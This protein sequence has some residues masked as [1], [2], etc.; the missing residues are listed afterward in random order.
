MVAKGMRNW[1][2]PKIAGIVLSL[3]LV[4]G[5][6]RGRGQ[7]TPAPPAPE[8]QPLHILV[9]KSVVVNMSTR[10]KR[11]LVSNPAVIE[12]LAT[13]PS[14]VVVEAKAAGTSSLILWDESGQ[15]HM[16][17]VTVDLNL[18]PLRSAIQRA[19]P[20][21][22]VQAQADGGRIILSGIV[23]DSHITDDL[24]KM[25]GIYST[26]IVNSLTV[27]PPHQ[28]QILLEVRIVEVDRVKFDQFGVN[29]LST[30][31][32]NT[33]GTVTT[34]QF[35]PAGGQG[36][37]PFTLQ[38]IIGAHATGTSTTF[39]LTNLLNIFFFRPDIN[40]GATVQALEQR[41]V[42]QILAQPNLMA[43]DG[44]KA[45]FLA[46]GEFPFPV[47]Q[48]GINIGAVTIQFR[49]F[50]VRLDFTG[51]IEPNNIIRLQVAPEVSSLDF[52]NSV[53]ISG[54]T[55]PAISTRRA[56][57]VIELKDG[58]AFG[59]AGLL[60]QRVTA[61]LSK[62]PGIGDIPVLGELFRSHSYNR[63]RSELIVLVEPHITD[64]VRTGAIAPAA[65]P[66]AM[67][68]L[69]VPPFD[70]KLPGRKDLEKIPGPATN[71]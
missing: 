39:G 26:Q 43:L 71:K 18:E 12:A 47:V 32:L 51:Y 17:D 4:A 8:A 25:A 1:G 3:A 21:L 65:P 70:Q 5:G 52:T 23:P 36:G 40:L 22:Q 59:I 6:A 42:L 24:V 7:E 48:G 27:E 37:G 11:V 61:Q 62:I 28:R 41:N 19:Y 60:D 50:G 38:G 31:V 67:P 30:G 16:L 46:G 13:T 68:F 9:G 57:T 14:Q 15:S 56:E 33:P 34:Q 49:P 58:Q 53:T 2:I 20:D 45:S 10:L 63:S 69:K 35:T 44:Q 66:P 55:V 29:F 64:P 54:F